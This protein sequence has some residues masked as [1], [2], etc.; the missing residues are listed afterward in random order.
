MTQPDDV[1]A[2]ALLEQA[3]AIEPGYGQ[4]LGV[5]ATSYAFSAYNGWIDMPSAV[6]SAERLALA[7]IRADGEDPWAHY[8]LGCVHVL[9]RRFDDALAHLELALSLNPS[10]ALAQSTYGLTLAFSGRWEDAGVAT[11]RALRLS[12]RDPFSAI[13]NGIAGYAQFVGRN[14]EEAMRLAGASIRLRSDH[15]GGYR[16]LTAAAAMAGHPEIAAAA[17]E[18]LR[19]AQPNFSLAWITGNM[20]FKN[21]ADRDHYLEA[22]RRAGLS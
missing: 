7:A 4:A 22:F 10:F 6:V 11:A 1:V 18:K 14:Y 21:D 13:Y 9:M 2:R 20:P 15:V 12:P 16:V 3:I 17:L 19:R 8:A 5:L